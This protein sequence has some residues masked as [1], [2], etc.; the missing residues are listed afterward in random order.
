MGKLKTKERRNRILETLETSSEP[1]SGSFLADKFGV[2]RQVVVTD[3]AILRSQYPNLMATNRGYIMLHAD[4]CRRVFKVLHTD[5]E[6]EDELISIIELGGRVM[7]VYVDHRVYGTI[8][9]P[10]DICSRRDID[11][12]MDDLNSGASSPLKNI[13]SGYHF[14]TIEARS[15]EVL[16]EIEDMLRAKGY[17]LESLDAAVIYEPKSYS[18][19]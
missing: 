13:T 10:L 16:D 6:T 9:K 3:I 8:R 17:L 2:S 5:E 18:K 12:F 15:E 14:H 1:L 19:I 4:E 11:H 7:D